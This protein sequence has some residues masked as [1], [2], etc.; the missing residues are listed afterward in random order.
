MNTL[1]RMGMKKTI[2][3]EH[4]LIKTNKTVPIFYTFD[5]LSLDRPS[6]SLPLYVQYFEYQLVEKIKFFLQM[7]HNDDYSSNST[8]AIPLAWSIQK[9]KHRKVDR[10]L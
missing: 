3:R 7:S 2:K 4:R 5:L 8:M 1:D 9:K 10:T 6:S